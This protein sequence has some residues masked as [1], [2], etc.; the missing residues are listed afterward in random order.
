MVKKT[1]S[2]VNQ[3]EIETTILRLLEQRAPGKTICPS[4]V[5]RAVAGSAQRAAWE[6][7]M[8]P[9]RSVAARLVSERKIVITQKGQVID[10]NTAKGPIRFRLR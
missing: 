7:L 2:D 3:K 8:E 4:E 1:A 10:G 9:V 6:P 5:A